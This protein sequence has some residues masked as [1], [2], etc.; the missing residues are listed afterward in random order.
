MK[1]LHIGGLRAKWGRIVAVE[2]HDDRRIQELVSAHHNGRVGIL[3][4]AF[5]FGALNT[6]DLAQAE[7][8]LGANQA[9]QSRFAM[10]PMRRWNQSFRQRPHYQPAGPTRHAP[11]RLP[12]FRLACPHQSRLWP[13]SCQHQQN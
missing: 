8:R 2:L 5:G 7:T 11:I 12:L 9:D 10:L 13:K 4:F 6:A 1:M 3:L